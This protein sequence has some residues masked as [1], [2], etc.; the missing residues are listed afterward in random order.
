MTEIDMSAR[1]KEP[2]QSLKLCLGFLDS[3]QTKS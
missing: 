2:G 3:I 1:E